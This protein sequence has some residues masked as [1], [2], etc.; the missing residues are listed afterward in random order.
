[1]F[2]GLSISKEFFS[3]IHPWGIHSLD[4]SEFGASAQSVSITAHA[5]DWASVASKYTCLCPAFSVLREDAYLDL[6]NMGEK[7]IATG[8]S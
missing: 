8:N 5:L 4:S 3:D 6:V 1:M 2:S 7:S